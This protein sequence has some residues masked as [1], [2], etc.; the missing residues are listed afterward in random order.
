MES[1]VELIITFLI[2]ASSEPPSN[3]ESSVE[4]IKLDVSRTFPQLCIFQKVS[5]V[6]KNMTT[7]VRYCFYGEFEI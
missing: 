1:V 2:L 5:F 6:K 4:L 7:T 3:K